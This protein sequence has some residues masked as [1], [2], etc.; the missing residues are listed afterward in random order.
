[1]K[2]LNPGRSQ[3]VDAP[4]YMPLSIPCQYPLSPIFSTWTEQILRRFM[5]I[6]TVAKNRSSREIGVAAIL[7]R[8]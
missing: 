3:F 2:L 4:Y 6:R 1:M 5:S 7:H 8:R